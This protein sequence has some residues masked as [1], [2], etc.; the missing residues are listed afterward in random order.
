MRHL[1]PEYRIDGIDEGCVVGRRQNGRT[2]EYVGRDGYWTRY[3][4]SATPFAGE[5][6][7]RAA[8]ERQY[9]D[10]RR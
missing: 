6:E 9:E 1:P 8:A 4:E 10:D 7:A 2:W 3:P 5:A